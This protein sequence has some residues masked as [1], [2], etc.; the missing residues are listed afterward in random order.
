MWTDWQEIGWRPS[1]LDLAELHRAWGAT[2]KARN[3][4]MHLWIWLNFGK[5]SS[6]KLTYKEYREAITGGELAGE[7]M[8]P[9]KEGWR[10]SPADFDQRPEESM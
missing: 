5:S 6:K 7:L 2:R 9:R 10:T 1:K 4:D 8:P 3:A